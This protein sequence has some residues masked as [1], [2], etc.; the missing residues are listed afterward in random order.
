MWK[1]IEASGISCSVLEHGEPEKIFIWPYAAHQS[2]ELADMEREISAVP[3]TQN[4]ILAAM[5]IEDWDAELS[6]WEAENAFGVDDFAGHAPDTLSRIENDL[7]PLLKSEYPSC[8]K[9]YTVGY[10]LA[11]L[12]ALWSLYNTDV[13]SGCA[14]CSGSMWIDEWDDYVHENR[15]KS[16][17]DI[18]LSLGGKEEKVSNYIMARVGDRTREQDRILKSDSNVRYSTLEWN[19]GGHFSDTTKRLAKGISWLLKRI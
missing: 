17:A 8:E 14:C 15:I 2:D 11:G 19:S 12:F 5:K 6:P 9:F 7:L 1:E 3:P 18:Y 16:K 13:F 10:S 4:F